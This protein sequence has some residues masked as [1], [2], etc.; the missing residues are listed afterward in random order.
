MGDYDDVSE[1]AFPRQ[2]ES[3]RLVQIRDEECLAAEEHQETRARNNYRDAADD[4][5]PTAE[6][7]CHVT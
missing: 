5:A 1:R 2:A 4:I 3:G 6:P 7:T